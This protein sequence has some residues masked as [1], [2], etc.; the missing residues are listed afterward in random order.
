MYPRYLFDTSLASTLPKQFF[1]WWKAYYA[2]SGSPFQNIK[3]ILVTNI[4]PT[5]ESF[6][7]HKKPHREILMKI[8]TI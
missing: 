6:I 4:N 2:F 1:Q 5:L 7:I 3:V 8:E